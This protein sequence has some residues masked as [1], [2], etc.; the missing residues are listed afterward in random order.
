[1]AIRRKKYV[2]NAETHRFEKHVR[3]TRAWTVRIFGFLASSTVTGVII[4]AL[5]FRFGQS[6]SEKRAQQELRQMQERFAYLQR[7]LSILDRDLRR[8]EER[9]NGVYR[10]IFESEPL[11]DSIRY[12]ESYRPRDTARFRYTDTRVLLAGVERSAEGLGHR[13]AV[14]AR[15]LDTLQKLV[16]AKEEMLASIPAIQPVSNKDL[17]RIASGFGYRIDPVYKTPKMHAGLDFAAPLGTPIYATANGRVAQVAYEETG[18]GTHVILDH[19]FGYRTLY[20]HMIKAKARP[21]EKVQR[22][23]VIGWV[24]STGKST[25]PHVHY[26]VI[27][28]T[29]K[30]DPV[31]F[32]FNDLSPED[33]ERLVRIAAASG[34]S[35]D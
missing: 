3:S 32:F 7:Q 27:R 6:P 19:G 9:D 18:Y 34:Q 21:G 4:A 31:H 1:M 26:E 14:Q 5:I 13:M 2:Y 24:G 22:G 23:E 16:E 15:S 11:P 12:G 33:Y 20:G 35:F 10:A 8:V 30:T 29:E 28:N 17:S 25:G